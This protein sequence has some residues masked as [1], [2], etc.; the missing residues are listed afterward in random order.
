[1]RLLKITGWNSG[2]FLLALLLSGCSFQDSAA[3]TIHQE[4]ARDFAI[5]IPQQPRQA[6]NF[7]LRNLQGVEMSLSDFRGEFLFLHF[8]TTW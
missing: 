8:S 3:S 4:L 6:P 5:Q 7:T 1:M 2:L